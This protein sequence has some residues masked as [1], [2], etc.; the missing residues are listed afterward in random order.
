MDFSLTSKEKEILL[1]AARQAITAKIK[2]IE[3]ESFETTANLKKQS[4]VFVSLHI[5]TALKGC[6]GYLTSE[7]PL[8]D[9]V[10]EAA[11]ASA[12]QDLRFSPLK[13]NET[14][15]VNIEISVLSEMKK[16]TRI[17]EIQVGEHGI[18]IKQGYHSGLLLPQ[19]ATENGWDRETFL[20]NTCYK[21]GLPGNCWKEKK[22]VIEIFSALVFNEDEL[23]LHNRDQ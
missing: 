9:T 21:A 20:T 6:I 13:E 4:G 3:P 14:D 1:K 8:L 16:I 19:V 17:E 22:T 12:F 23:D 10:K 15:R 2:K 18:L 5:D 11:V 7:K